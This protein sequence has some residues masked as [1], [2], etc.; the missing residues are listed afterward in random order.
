MYQEKENQ[1]STPPKG[2][3]RIE[4]GR[5]VWRKALLA[6]T[7]MSSTLIHHWNG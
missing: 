5:S 6:K 3:D 1:G 7:A 4:N 2:G